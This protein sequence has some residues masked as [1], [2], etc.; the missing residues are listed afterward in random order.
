MVLSMEAKIARPS[1]SRCKLL[2][3]RVYPVLSFAKVMSIY[4]CWDAWCNGTQFLS[5]PR[6][7]S[8]ILEYKKVQRAYLLQ[9]LFS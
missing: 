5:D 1:L 4:A 3:L 7:A 9:L 2:R 6:T 8:N